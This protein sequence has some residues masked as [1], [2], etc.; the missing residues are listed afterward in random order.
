[1][2]ISGVVQGVGYRYYCFEY[3]KKLNINGYAKNLD[4]GNVEVIADGSQSA[5]NEYLKLLK[6]GPLTST[7]TAINITELNSTNKY[8]GFE[9]Y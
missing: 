2:I 4:N 6:I 5:I 1:M 3:A 7:V 9:I 8:E